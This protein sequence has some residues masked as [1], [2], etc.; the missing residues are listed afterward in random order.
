MPKSNVMQMLVRK[1]VVAYFTSWI[2]VL[3]V[4][5]FFTNFGGANWNAAENYMSS[6]IFVALYAVPAVFLYGIIVSS[7]IEAVFAML[8]VKGS[9]EPMISCS[10]HVIFG[11]CFGIVL[12]S[13]LFSI[14]GGVAAI[15]FY[16]LDRII[17]PAI[18][19]FKMKI[20]V[21]SFIAPVFLVVLIV[22]VIYATAPPKRPFT[23]KDAVRYATDTIHRFPSK[24]GVIKLQIEGYDVEQ[25]TE[26]EETAEK[27][28]Y[29]VV[30]TE[31]WRKR[32]ESGFYQM[33]YEVSRGRMSARGGSG[34]HP[35]YLQ[36]R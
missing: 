35:P 28:T 33:I 4:S 6:A 8:K 26:V 14:M 29:K 18:L 36:T 31:R 11:L 12:E 30:F 10:F 13:T 2:I 7:L 22:G 25:E 23:A 3:L 1:V 24:E 15:L 17:V 27:E 19:G 21:I 32:E 9:A 34:E 5:V 16:S 20:R